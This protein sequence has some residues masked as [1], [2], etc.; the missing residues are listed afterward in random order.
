MAEDRGLLGHGEADRDLVG[1][2]N[3]TISDFVLE[4]ISLVRETARL[5]LP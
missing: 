1:V 4:T 2:S 3:S 5:D